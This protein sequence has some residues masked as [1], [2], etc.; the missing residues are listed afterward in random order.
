MNDLHQLL[1]PYACGWPFVAVA[2]FLVFLL[3][4]AW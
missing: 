3:Y 1:L 4:L 2:S